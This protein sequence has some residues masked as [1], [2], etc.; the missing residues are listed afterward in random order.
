M[1]DSQLRYNYE[2]PEAMKQLLQSILFL[3]LFDFLF[4]LF[5]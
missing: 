4:H 3:P 2:Y 1:K 5:I